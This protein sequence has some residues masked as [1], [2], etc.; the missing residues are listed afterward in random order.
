MMK[1]ICTD[2]DPNI[3]CDFEATGNGPQEVAKKML[4]HMKSAHA[5]SYKKMNMSD[6]DVMKM[7]EY[8]VHT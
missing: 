8:K 2:V 6:E 1:L 3:A 4:A 5:D 7:L